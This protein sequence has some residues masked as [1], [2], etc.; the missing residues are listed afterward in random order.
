MANSVALD[1]N[2]P[3]ST[4][5]TVAPVANAKLVDKVVA[6]ETFKPSFICTSVESSELIDV[7]ENFNELALTAPVPCGAKTISLLVVETML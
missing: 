7:P 5:V 2:A 3:L 6:P 4:P 1:P